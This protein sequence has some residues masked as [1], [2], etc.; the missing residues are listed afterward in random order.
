M[1]KLLIV[2]LFVNAAFLAG[3]WYEHSAVAEGEG[4]AGGANPCEADPTKYSLDA[5]ADGKVDVA[6]FVFGLGWVFRGTDAPNIC[7]D[8]SDL[9]A[10]LVQAEAE[11]AQAREEL[12]ALID[13]LPPPPAP[14][15]LMVQDSEGVSF[16]FDDV[17]D[18]EC[19]SEAFWSG[20]MTMTG[21]D[22]DT[23]WFTDRPDRLAY[24]EGTAEFISGFGETFSESTG[25]NPNAVLNWEDAGDGTEKHAVIELR[26][27]DETSPSYD[28]DSAV[29]T[30]SVCGLRLD[31]PETLQTLPDNEQFQPPEDV[32]VY[33]RLS[34]FID[35]T[36][37]IESR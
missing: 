30:Y 27:V 33:G 14:S 3:N 34:L 19:P 17:I 12:A 28:A 23:L 31:D 13:A 9:E 10:R 37:G 26:Y 16:D 5:N 6:D 24:T 20:T 2:A 18:E 22:P 11:L 7:L 32:S 29:L 21:A 36:G 35:S 15:W 25:G 4:R 8:S 1:R